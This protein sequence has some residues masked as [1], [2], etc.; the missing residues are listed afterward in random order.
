MPKYEK[1]RNRMLR[2]RL[3]K[4]VE[5]KKSKLWAFINSGIV[6]WLLSALLL[7]VG[8]GYVTNHAQCMK[9]AEQ[10]INRQSMFIQ[11][12]YG[13]ELAFK[14]TVDDAKTVQ[15][16]PFLPGSDGSIWPELAKLQYL[17]VLQEFGLLNGR[18]AY[19]DLPDDFIAKARAKWIEFNI[20]KQN[21]ISEN[22][23]KSQLPGP[24]P[25]TDPA[26]FFKFR[27]LLGQLQFEDQSFQHDL[28]AVAYYFEPN[29]TVVNTFFLALGYKPQIMAARVSPVYKEETFKQIFKDAIARISALQSELHA[30]LLQLYG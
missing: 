9:E 25:K 14:T 13:R 30:V 16:I 29:C 1:I 7:S 28:N 26:V 22:F 17:Q 27:K 5:P 20:A 3:A 21:K 6:L 23:D 4:P 11:E 15:K 18:V 10:L 24:Q 12:L 2:E 19:D 8:G